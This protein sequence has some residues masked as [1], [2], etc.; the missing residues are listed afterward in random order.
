MVSPFPPSDQ[1]PSTLKDSLEKAGSARRR[2]VMP[3]AIQV[4]QRHPG[5]CQRSE[6]LKG[7]LCIALEHV[8]QLPALPPSVLRSQGV[9]HGGSV[10]DDQRLKARL[11][12]L[13]Q[14][15]LVTGNRGPL[16]LA[17]EARG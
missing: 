12:Q 17:G 15:R 7:K 3:H 16:R 14:Q 11:Q 1:P 2:P 9:R 4:T 13:P 6:L 5:A 8:E 10:K